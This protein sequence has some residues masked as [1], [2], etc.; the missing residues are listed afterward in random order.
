MSLFSRR[1]PYDRKRLLD[2][3]N[4]LQGGWRWRKALAIYRQ[5]LAAEP[6]S[7]DLHA[8]VAPLLARTGRRLEAW[9]SFE[10]AIGAC[11][12]D[13]DDAS[14]R[15]L[16]QQAVRMLPDCPEPVRELAKAEVARQRGHEAI[17]LLV[18]G[19]RRMSRLRSRGAAILLLRDARTIEPWNAGVV[20]SLCRQLA[21]DGQPAEALFLLDHLEQRSEGEQLRAVRTMQWRIE[22]SLRHSWRWLRAAREPRRPGS[23]RA[24]GAATSRS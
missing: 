13:G 17:R 2:R 9:E 16:Q 8:R 11:L 6:H 7:A 14:A 19:S 18:E 1:I 23:R 20:L 5:V 10:I 4:A 24:D 22:P 12:R 3:A 21:R 15:T